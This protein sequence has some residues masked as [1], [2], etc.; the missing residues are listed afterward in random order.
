MGY[1]KILRIAFLNRT[2]GDYDAYV[3]FDKSE[4]ENMLNE[5]KDFISIIE[6]NL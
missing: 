3:R 6:F 2:K 5:M 4:V 1:G